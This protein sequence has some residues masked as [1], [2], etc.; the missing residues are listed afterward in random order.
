MSTCRTFADIYLDGVRFSLFSIIHLFIYFIYSSTSLFFFSSLF[1]LSFHSLIILFYFIFA[2]I[3]LLL[4]YITRGKVYVIECLELHSHM[5]KTKKDTQCGGSMKTK[6][7]TTIYLPY[8]E[9]L[10]PKHVN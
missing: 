8:L 1:F 5:Q 2:F 10:L 4:F 9:K 3:L 7:Q 6:I